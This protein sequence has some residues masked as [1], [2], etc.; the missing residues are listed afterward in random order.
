MSNQPPTGPTV[1][2]E[3]GT[4]AAGPG[5]APQP[6]QQ[7]PNNNDHTHH[8]PPPNKCIDPPPSLGEAGPA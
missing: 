3:P 4:E 8:G 2:P 5:P 6:A 7:Q 1:C